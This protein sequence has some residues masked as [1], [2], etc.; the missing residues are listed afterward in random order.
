MTREEKHKILEDII[1]YVSTI[2][3]AGIENALEKYVDEPEHEEHKCFEN[4]I[5]ELYSNMKTKITQY[6]NGIE[7]YY[8]ISR[9]DITD[10]NVIASL[11]PEE[12]RYISCNYYGMWLAWLGIPIKNMYTSSW[13]SA[14]KNDVMH[15]WSFETGIQNVNWIKELY[16]ITLDGVVRVEK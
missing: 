10:P 2:N 15:Y 14:R 1:P 4:Q 13:K 9:L 7:E 11:V 16:E 8:E 6:K 12:T 3:E 5:I